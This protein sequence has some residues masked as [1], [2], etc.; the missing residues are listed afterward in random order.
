[1][2]EGTLAAGVGVEETGA[3]EAA[4]VAGV[5]PASGFTDSAALVSLTAP[6]ALLVVSTPLA[7]V[8]AVSGVAVLGAFG[9]AECKRRDALLTS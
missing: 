3:L 9:S 8:A 2:S 1:M 7:S 6:P 5:D 4:D